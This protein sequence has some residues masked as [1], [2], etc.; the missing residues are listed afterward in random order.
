MST[1]TRTG[2]GG[3]GRN[4]GAK[5]TDNKTA[6]DAS[7]NNK[8]NSV[9]TAVVKT[10]KEKTQVKAKQPTAEQIRIAQITD[11]KQNDDPKILDKVNRLMEMTQRSEEEVC[12]ALNECE[13]DMEKA[14][15]FLLETLPVG[16]FATTSKKKKNRLT[17]TGNDANAGD[18]E[19]NN[20]NSNANSGSTQNQS[21]DSKDRNRTRGGGRGG[22]GGGYGGG[23]GRGRPR[24]SRDGFDRDKDRSDMGR[25]D[26]YRSRGG[27]GGSGGISGGRGGYGGSG[28][29]GRGG[30]MG[31]RNL[32]MR[33]QRPQRM[34]DHQEI[35][36]WEPIT[37]TTNDDLNKSADAWGDWDN[38]EYTGSLSDTKVFTPSTQTQS[39]VP[40]EY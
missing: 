32:G 33:E 16:A 2:G 35:D 6:G 10:E 27:R 13:N 3:G 25:R 4:K 14:V 7:I 5:A 18:G 40:S 31:S 28:R 11:I 34:T 36:S 26:D 37:T 22:G 17:S 8:K 30:R 9:E 24:E 1:Q 29:G 15:I 20:E 21:I 23:S 19:W 12:C 39:A 38:E